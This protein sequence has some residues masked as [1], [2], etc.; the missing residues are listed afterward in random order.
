MSDAVIKNQESILINQE[1]ILGNQ[2]KIEHNQARL[3]K[4]AANQAAILANQELIRDNQSKLDKLV[5]NQASMQANQET[6]MGNQEKL[7]KAVGNQA[8]IVANQEIIQANQEK[9]S[10]GQKEIMA[11]QREM[12]ED[13][14]RDLGAL[15]HPS[16]RRLKVL[17]RR[18]RIRCHR[19]ADCRSPAAAELNR[20]ETLPLT[21]GG[22]SWPSE[23][24]RNTRRT[25]RAPR[26]R[27]FIRKPM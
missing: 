10:E 24:K 25:K 14:I 11:N 6:I 1:K 19:P 23:R 7:D 8:T 21:S 5:A 26:P 18:E 17:A 3:D 22:L 27:A 15:T 20:P 12:V 4:I 9:L 16:H 2:E 13:V